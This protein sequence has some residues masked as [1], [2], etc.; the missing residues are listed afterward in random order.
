[1]RNYHCL[2]IQ[3]LKQGEKLEIVAIFNNLTTVYFLV[4]NNFISRSFLWK[5]FELRQ[6]DAI[7]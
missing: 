1:M 4:A 6:N 2:S 5:I 7:K 3:F